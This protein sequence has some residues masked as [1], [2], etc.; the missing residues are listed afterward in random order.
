L[1]GRLYA[2]RNKGGGGA[3]GGGG[4]SGIFE[5]EAPRGGGVV[6]AA[7]GE[8]VG[9]LFHFVVKGPVSLAR[10]RSAMLPIVSGPIQG[11][12][13]SLYNPNVLRQ[14]PLN[15]VYLT[16]DTGL[17]LLEGPVTVF[18]GTGGTSF[19]G[20]A[21]M[22][23]LIPKGRAI[24][25]YAAD[26]YVTV[27]EK[28]EFSEKTLGTAI[29]SGRVT[30][31]MTNTETWTY[32]IASKADQTRTVVVCVP[33]RN[34]W[35]VVEPAAVEERT[36]D[37]VRAK[38]AVP[39]NSEQKF[40][41]RTQGP[42]WGS[43]ELLGDRADPG[44]E[45]YAKDPAIPQDVRT[46]LE[47]VRQMHAEIAK[48]EAD[49]TATANSREAILAEQGRLRENIKAVGADNRLA[50]RYIEKLNKQED[51]IESMGKAIEQ[52]NEQV[53]GK[54]EALTK[55]VNSLQVGDQGIVKEFEKMSSPPQ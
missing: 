18:D 51:Q 13:V 33:R 14:H 17:K 42:G 46:A 32:Q 21:M 15:A 10:R 39:A 53:K 48:L 49:R 23:T 30:V 50:Q 22:D 38:V 35:T 25:C 27:D 7:R 24:L 19:A 5:E 41:V 11:E 6:A 3:M 54:E 31:K 16:N 20:E 8:K 9:E 40:V 47:K 4:T 26:L 28:T 34:N 2:M 55:H 12:K 52:F 37:E 44:L 1:V 45:R 29:G 36:D 43:V